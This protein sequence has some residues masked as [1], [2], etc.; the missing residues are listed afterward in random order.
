MP[1]NDGDIIMEKRRS[2]GE[3]S[4]AS[5]DPF[6]R[7]RP[8]PA[9]SPEQVARLRVQ[10]RRREYL[11]KNPGYFDSVEHELADPDLYDTV[12]RRFQTPEEREAEGKSRGWGKVLESSLIRSEAR[13]E[14]V[15]SSY[16]GDVPPAATRKMSSLAEK[17]NNGAATV[18]A[19]PTGIT[20]DAADLV[21]SK[22]A[23]QEEGRA[24][25]E[26]F[27][28]ER[29]V[30]GEDEDFDYTAVDGNE[31]FDEMEQRDRDEE[32][33]DE[34]DPE[35]AD[36]SEDDD[37]G[38]EGGAEMRRAKRERILTGETGVQDY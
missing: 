1:H 14:R 34:E 10:N 4:P 21:D 16:T 38:E 24:A 32:W 17:D 15:A 29:F 27:L 26:D 5:T 8:L 23:T 30:N 31:E 22:P 33:F 12:V 25:W 18:A 13:L 19:A 7:P 37:N 36:D 2:N 3:S 20:L 9:R 35:W 28:R 6:S 11:Q